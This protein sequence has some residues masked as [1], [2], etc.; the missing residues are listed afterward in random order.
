MIYRKFYFHSF[1]RYCV[2]YI[3]KKCCTV[4]RVVS[5]IWWLIHESRTFRF[6]TPKMSRNL[7]ATDKIIIKNVYRY[8][9]NSANSYQFQCLFLLK[10]YKKNFWSVFNADSIHK[11]ILFWIQQ[12]LD[13][14]PPLTVINRRQSDA[15]KS[16]MY[17]CIAGKIRF[18]LF[19]S[20]NNLF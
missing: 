5:K 14:S 3:V 9:T 19:L 7:K 1:L 11:N 16:L 12:I 4:L 8:R 15:G 2:I 18:H 20:K 10:I 6:D 13:F 17:R